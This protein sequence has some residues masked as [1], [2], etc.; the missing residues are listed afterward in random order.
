MYDS[1]IYSGLLCLHV[2]EHGRFH[3]SF[4]LLLVRYSNFVKY[5]VT[6]L[7][8]S[9]NSVQ[10]TQRNSYKIHSLLSNLCNCAL[11]KLG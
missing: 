3:C 9:I 1:P 10:E 7:E 5:R 6:C 8:T 4:V 2:V 11:Q